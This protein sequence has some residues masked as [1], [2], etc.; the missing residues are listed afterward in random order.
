MMVRAYGFLTQEIAEQTHGIKANIDPFEQHKWDGAV[1]I[2]VY[3]ESFAECEVKL[4]SALKFLGADVA[5]EIAY[6]TSE[7]E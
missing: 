2:T 4:A 3:S 6:P 1:N 7:G 5:V